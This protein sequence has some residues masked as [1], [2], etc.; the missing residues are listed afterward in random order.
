ML[1]DFALAPLVEFH[2]HHRAL[3]TVVAHPND[4]PRSSDLIVESDGLVKGILPR[5]QPRNGDFRN[6]VP[7]GLYLASPA[8]FTE[9]QP[10]TKTDMICDLLPV[11]VASG[12]RLAT[13]NTP[14]YL[15]DIGTP[16]RF[17][18][19]EHDLVA[20]QVAMLNRVHPRPAI[21]FDCD[22]VLNEETGLQGVVAPDEVRII[23]GAGAAV[24][25]AR[26][27]GRLTVAITN[28]PQ[29][30]K[31]FITFQGLDHILGRLEALLA[32]DKGVLDRI[33]FCPHYPQAGF[34]G[35]IPALKIKCE[36]RKPGTLLLR[37]AFDEL[38]VNRRPLDIHW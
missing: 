32:E 30:A 21:F 19:A 26:E 6:L 13:Y 18:M 3:L 25:R 1:F 38:P 8:F 23:P 4:H 16:T 5:G 28:R 9:I 2:R 7:A 11:L 31:G 17:E 20:G 35:E 36:C 22:G 24:R 29:V 27:G 10:R 34:L 33:Y 15:R 12:R 37:R 14:E